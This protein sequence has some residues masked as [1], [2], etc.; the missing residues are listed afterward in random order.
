MKILLLA[1][2]LLTSAMPAS[3]LENP[4]RMAVGERFVTSKG[5]AFVLL[6]RSETGKEMWFDEAAKVTWGDRLSERIRRQ[7]A[8]GLCATKIPGENTAAGRNLKE[9]PT[10][11][12]FA[13]AESH[14]F[15]EVL[16]NM[17]DSYYWVNSKIKGAANIGHVFSGNL[18]RPILILYRAINYENIRCIARGAL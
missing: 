1:I 12:D 9:L 15:R 16:P 8:A 18:G 13:T 3:A 5:F 11:A 17:T 7:A 14:G 4:R 2:F 6:F 10:L